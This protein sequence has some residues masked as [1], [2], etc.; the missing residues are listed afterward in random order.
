MSLGLLP[1]QEQA[2]IVRVQRQ[3][4]LQERQKEYK[5]NDKKVLPHFPGCI[6]A[7]KHSDIPINSQFSNPALKSFNT[8]RINAAVNL[9]ITHLTT[10][11]SNWSDFDEFKKM[12]T[13]KCNCNL[14]LL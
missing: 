13:G 7:S 6:N 9:G 12:Y 14:K 3:F 5:W 8:G 11:L 10:L 4:Q 1:H 2:D